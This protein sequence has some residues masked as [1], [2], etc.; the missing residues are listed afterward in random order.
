MNERLTAPVKGACRPRIAA[1]VCAASAALLAT[2]AGAQQVS[3]PGDIII[4]RNITPRSAFDAVPKSQDPVAV[5]ATTFPKNS[6]DPA[7]AQLVSDADLTNAHG[8]SG[9]N[10]GAALGGAAA[11]VQA[12][13]RILAGNQTGSNVP[14]GA[15][16]Q[17]GGGLGGTISSSVTSALAPL[18]GALGALK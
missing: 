15:G 18:T 9:V 1:A 17:A 3:N 13:T 11:S 12:V 10:T 5:R 4:E 14:L 6:F 16:A 8:S 2:A 7:I